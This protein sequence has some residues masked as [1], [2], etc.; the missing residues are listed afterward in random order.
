MM[1]VFGGFLL[2]LLLLTNSNVADGV[3]FA[4][5]LALCTLAFPVAFEG[6][7]AEKLRKLIPDD[8]HVAISDGERVFV[9]RGTRL[10]SWLSVSAAQLADAGV[11]PAAKAQSRVANRP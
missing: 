9:L 1:M 8:T 10:V 7:R 11:F 6:G 3:G 5:V 4:V 2:A